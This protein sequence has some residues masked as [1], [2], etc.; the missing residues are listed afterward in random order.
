MT[1]TYDAWRRF[2]AGRDPALLESLLA[3]EVVFSAPTY[4]KPRTGKVTVMIVLMAV[5][6]VLEDFTYHREWIDERDWALEFS[7]R[8]GDL[9]LKGIDLVSL[10]GAGK[11]SGLE[12]LIRPPNA[13]AALRAAMEQKLRELQAPLS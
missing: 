6:E 3:D 11:I 2:I 12:V 13:V 8:V 7:A 10:D 1:Q 9:D 5:T 4:W